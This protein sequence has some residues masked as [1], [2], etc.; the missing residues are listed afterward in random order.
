MTKV[1]T[2]YRPIG[3]KELKLI[4]DSDWRRFPPR[5]PEQPIFY[6][7]ENEEYARLIARDWNVR[8]DGE[9]HVVRFSVD[10]AFIERYPVHQVGSAIHQERWIPAEEL[11]DFNNHIIGPIELVASYP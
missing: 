11:D 8:S 2:L 9:G 3:P 1:T 10:S 5:L 7:V 6:P 4:C